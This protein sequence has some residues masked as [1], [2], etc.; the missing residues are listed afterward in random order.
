MLLLEEAGVAFF[1]EDQLAQE[2]IVGLTQCDIVGR[3]VGVAECDGAA[4]A[5]VTGRNIDVFEA[6]EVNDAECVFVHVDLVNTS[7][8]LAGDNREVL[9][10]EYVGRD[11][12]VLRTFVGQVVVVAVRVVAV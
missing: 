9:V 11:A 12:A 5:A 6:A 7:K 3:P 8:L 10:E 1:V 2:V 4:V